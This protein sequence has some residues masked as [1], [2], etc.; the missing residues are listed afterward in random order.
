MIRKKIQGFRPHPIQ[1]IKTYS[2][3]NPMSALYIKLKNSIFKL[4]QI[5]IH[6]I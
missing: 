5:T 6:P 4:I 3:L 2:Y 1:K